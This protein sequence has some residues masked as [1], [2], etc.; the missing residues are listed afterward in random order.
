VKSGKVR[1]LGF[2][3]PKRLSAL[4]DVPTIAEA[5]LPGYVADAGWHAVFA[6]ART[7]PAVVN[8]MYAA[9]RK[10]L[11]V[12]QVREHFVDGGYEP[13]GAPPAEWT[14]LF[15]DDLRRYAEICRIAKIEMQ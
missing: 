9:I 11:A 13:Q 1:A 6:P 5:G 7:P 8:R 10:A 12:P 14:K 4:P 3:G 2:T 15:R